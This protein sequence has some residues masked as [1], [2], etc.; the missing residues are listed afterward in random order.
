MKNISK[1]LMTLFVVGL[2]N[3]TTAQQKV[4]KGFGDKKFY[5]AA[6]GQP[7]RGSVASQKATMK[8]GPM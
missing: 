2:I 4:E 7:G 8:N 3:T 5:F 1:V 6:W